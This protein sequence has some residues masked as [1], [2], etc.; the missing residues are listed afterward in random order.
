MARN[1]DSKGGQTGEHLGNIENHKCFHNNVSYGELHISFPP[2]YQ[3]QRTF[4]ISE[5][6]LGAE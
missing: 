2:I 3:S 6:D 1:N 5:S 4:Y